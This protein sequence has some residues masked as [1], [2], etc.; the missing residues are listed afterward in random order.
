MIKIREEKN[1]LFI[2]LALLAARVAAMALMPLNEVTEARYG[3]MA[4]KMLE[5]GNWVTPMHDYGVPF[6]AKPPMWAWLSAASLGVFGVNEFAARLPS[7][8]L[9][10]G[11]LALAV[12]AAYKRSGRETAGTA[13]L[14]LA[15]CGGFFVAAGTVMTDPSLVFCTTL[16]MVSFWFGVQAK[17]NIWGWLFFVGVG[18]GLLAKGPVAIVITGLPIF[19]WVIMRKQWKPLWQNLPWLRGTLLTLAIALPWYILAEIHTPGF[20]QYFIIGEHIGRFLDKGWKGD[21]YGFAHAYPLGTIWVFALAGLLPWSLPM[22]KKIKF[23]RAVRRDDDGWMLFVTLWSFMSLAFFTLAAN[24]I[25]PYCLPALPGFALLMAESWT[26][27][28]AKRPLLPAALMAGLGVIAV[29]AFIITPRL[30]DASEKDAMAA[31]RAQN[32]DG[33][34]K[35]IMWGR[36]QEFSAEFYSGGRAKSTFDPQ[37]TEELLHDDTQDYIV[38]PLKALPSLPQDVRD[39][40]EEI[41]RF[42]NARGDRVLLR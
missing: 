31:W 35:L 15:S 6:L 7:L 2:L 34:S 23:I 30:F 1:I 25:W 41:A 36:K 9:G 21:Q 26:R 39:G 24:I 16:I 40:F 13:A 37:V 27:M 3:E 14:A 17:N 4:R 10:I 29:L 19:C 32:P 33:A 8:L 18:L 38:S 11:T 42:K 5:T 20:L 28:G 22:L 12:F